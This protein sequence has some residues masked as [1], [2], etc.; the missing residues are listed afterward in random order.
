MPNDLHREL[1]DPKQAISL[2]SPP[3]RDENE[4]MAG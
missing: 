1:H 3:R 2:V 4:L